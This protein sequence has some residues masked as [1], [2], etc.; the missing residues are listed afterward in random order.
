[1]T[2]GRR[3]AALA[4]AA[5]LFTLPAWA[6]ERPTVTWH[7]ARPH[8]GAVAWVHV[9]GVSEATTIEG[10]LG[11]RPLAFFPYA[12]G[13][14]A[15]VGIDLE[16]KPGVEPWRLAGRLECRGRD[17]ARAGTDRPCGARC[18]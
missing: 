5:L 7:P 6:A 15:V 10:A 2:A 9:R 4:G 18:W 14:A 1:V 11:G 8:L 12:G 3:L 13:Q 17:S 16:T